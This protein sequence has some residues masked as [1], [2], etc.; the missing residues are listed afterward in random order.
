[1]DQRRVSANAPVRS[2]SNETTFEDDTA[3]GDILDGHI[4]R[5]A[6][7]V[8]DR[9]KAKALAG[10]V[11]TLKLKRTDFSLVTRR[12][13]LRQPTQMA[14]VIYRE[15]RTL[16]DASGADGPFR[17]IGVG[18]SELVPEAAADVSADLLDRGATARAGAERAADSVRARFG[19]EAILKGRSLR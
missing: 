16:F 12:H 18:L 11:V 4:W 13:A 10:R 1:V 9:A 15:A 2:L 17:L 5:M 14:D 19:R 3:D 6:E 8:S 7:K